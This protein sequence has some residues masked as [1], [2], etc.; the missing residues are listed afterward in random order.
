MGCPAKPP[1]LLT[2]HVDL[3]HKRLA[4]AIDDYPLQP[5]LS[6][7]PLWHSND[8]LDAGVSLTAQLAVRFNQVVRKC[9]VEL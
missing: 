9:I 8:T 4:F 7:I 1:F 3:K 2:I 6:P 5:I